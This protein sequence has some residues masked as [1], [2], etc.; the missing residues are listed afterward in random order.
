MLLFQGLIAGNKPNKK[1]AGA[2]NVQAG[3]VN[4]VT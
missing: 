1:P 2:D 3:F 4:D